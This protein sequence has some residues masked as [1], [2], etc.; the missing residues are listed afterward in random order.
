MWKYN[1]EALILNGC[2]NN[3]D[4]NNCYIAVYHDNV[5]DNDYYICTAYIAE[6]RIGMSS[7]SYHI[8]K[9]FFFLWNT[10]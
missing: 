4:N 9:V 1:F 5:D 7:K 3:N 6:N 8:R 2:N 10:P